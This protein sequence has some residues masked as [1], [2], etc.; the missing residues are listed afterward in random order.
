ML[1]FIDIKKIYIPYSCIKESYEIMRNAGKNGKEAVALFV[2]EIKNTVFIVQKTIVPK[3]KPYSSALGLMYDVS[4][5]ELLQ[6]NL[7]L[8]RTN[9][10]IIA[11]I[12]SHPN[13][14]FHSPTDNSY[15]IVPTIGG[16]SIVVPEFASGPIDAKFWSVYRLSSYNKWE[17]MSSEEVD[18][19]IHVINNI[20]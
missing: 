12:H 15:S 19:L 6:L 7:Y 5:E 11:Q 3:Q 20:G 4:S 13:E 18:E 9:L 16:L 17:K 2:G 8:H 10:K 14:A 1:G